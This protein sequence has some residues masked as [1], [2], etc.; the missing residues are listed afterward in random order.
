[1][2]AQLWLQKWQKLAE[3]DE[4]VSGY[5]PLAWDN[6]KREMIGSNVSDFTQDKLCQC[7]YIRTEKFSIVDYEAFKNF[8]N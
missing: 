2:L 4:I 1:M 6:S 7:Y 3:T 5:N 8:K